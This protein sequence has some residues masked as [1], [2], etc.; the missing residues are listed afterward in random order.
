[1]VSRAMG[2][3]KRGQTLIP[4]PRIKWVR[5]P[6]TWRQWCFYNTTSKTVEGAEPCNYKQAGESKLFA[7]KRGQATEMIVWY[8]TPLPCHQGKTGGEKFRRGYVR[9]IV[10]CCDPMAHS[11]FWGTK[12]NRLKISNWISIKELRP[13][14]A[15]NITFSMQKTIFSIYFYFWKLLYN[16]KILQ[17]YTD[18][19]FIPW[20]FQSASHAPNLE[21]QQEESGRGENLSGCIYSADQC[22]YWAFGI[23]YS[24]LSDSH[25][26]PT[27][28]ASSIKWV[29]MLLYH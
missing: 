19:Y 3:L 4:N 23:N 14:Q 8:S 13:P 11:H 7:A 24:E 29:K 25:P 1:M 16:P 22:S 28:K 10:I 17:N 27:L 9:M 6:L 15:G 26:T 18:I 12:G 21:N 2:A 20:H 5:V